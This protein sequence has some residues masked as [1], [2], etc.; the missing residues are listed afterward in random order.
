MTKRVSS[1]SSELQSATTRYCESDGKQTQS[2]G[3][4]SVINAL[5]PV[6]EGTHLAG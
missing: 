2:H 4:M 3:M 6:V 1:L 5:K